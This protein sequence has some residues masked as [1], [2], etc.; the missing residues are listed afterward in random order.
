M[1]FHSV[2]EIDTISTWLMTPE[3]NLDSPLGTTIT[4]FTRTVDVPMYADRLYVKFST[5]RSST[6][7]NDF[8]NI[9]V[10]VNENLTLQPYPNG[11]PN[12]WTQISATIP[13]QSAGTSGRFAFHYSVPNGGSQ[14]S[15][16][17]YIGIDTVDIFPFGSSPS[18][19]P[20]VTEGFE[21]VGV[22]ISSS[23]WAVVGNF[24]LF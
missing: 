4:F 17:D 12:T 11:Y 24:C 2:D 19:T 1:N 5:N 18:P 13:T 23:S 8:S 10:S 20:S 7:P 9:L 3:F 21:N 16:S 14:G 22:L 15:N 6:N